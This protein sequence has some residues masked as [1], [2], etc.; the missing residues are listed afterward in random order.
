MTV[1]FLGIQTFLI[2]TTE[3]PQIIGVDQLNDEM[4]ST[5][6]GCFAEAFRAR[7]DLFSDRLKDAVRQLP[8]F[9]RVH[10]G[11]DRFQSLSVNMTMFAPE[12]ESSSIPRS[13]LDFVTTNA[14]LLV[15]RHPEF[16]AALGMNANNTDTR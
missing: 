4:R 3:F 8:I 11:E 2:G 6:L 12:I 13:F 1:C 15:Y 10:G 9:E 14:N 5:L 16:H 7:G